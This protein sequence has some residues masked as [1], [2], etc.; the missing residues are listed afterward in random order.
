MGRTTW[1]NAEDTNN[2]NV[3]DV[4]LEWG[5]E[6]LT[7]EELSN[8]LLL[9]KDDK[10]NNAWSVAGMMGNTESLEKIWKWAKM[11]LTPEEQKNIILSCKR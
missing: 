1:H 10:Q 11:D 3:L 4:L 6:E 8:K 7:T 9:D 5:K 2:T